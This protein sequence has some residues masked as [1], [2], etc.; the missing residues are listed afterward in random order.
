MGFWK[1]VPLPVGWE[2]VEVG[3]LVGVFI[4]VYA[5]QL[6]PTLLMMWGALE[7]GRLESYRWAVASSVVALVSA[8]LCGNYFSLPGGIWALVLLL[9]PEVKAAFGVAAA[10]PRRSEGPTVGE[11]VPIPHAEEATAAHGAEGVQPAAAIRTQAPAPPRIDYE[12]VRRRVVRAANILT[13][14]VGFVCLWAV[15]LSLSLPPRF[16]GIVLLVVLLALM[17]SAGIV[18]GAYKMHRL[19]SYGWAMTGTV[20]LLVFSLGGFLVVLAT[21]GTEVLGFWGGCPPFLLGFLLGIWPLAVLLKAD[22]RAAFREN[23]IP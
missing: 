7:M 15:L 6:A 23:S 2:R 21:G 22:V 19:E 4:L 9:K 14:A 12:E 3:T 10:R 18:W 11:P 13:M 16:A 8:V 20:V 1:G 5:V 17:G